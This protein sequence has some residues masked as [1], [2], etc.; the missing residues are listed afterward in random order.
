V[1]ATRVNRFRIS[2]SVFIAWDS[3]LRITFT[4][5]FASNQAESGRSPLDKRGY[6]LAEVGPGPGRS[7]L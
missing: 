5:F 4:G 3:A 6:N 1:V 2:C 7:R